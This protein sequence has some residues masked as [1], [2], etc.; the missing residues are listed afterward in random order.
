MR[1]QDPGS[2]LHRKPCFTLNE[3]CQTSKRRPHQPLCFRAR[4]HHFSAWNITLP[5]CSQFRKSFQ[6]SKIQSHQCITRSNFLP[7][8]WRTWVL[9]QEQGMLEHR[10]VTQHHHSS[11]RYHQTLSLQGG[12]KHET[13]GGTTHLPMP[14]QSRPSLPH[15]IPYVHY[16]GA[17][18]PLR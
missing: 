3:L 8:L 11:L 12:P 10:Q 4:A 9:Y 13:I 14:R 18:S 2:P 17:R 1:T 15:Q 7:K 5:T 16:S 6:R